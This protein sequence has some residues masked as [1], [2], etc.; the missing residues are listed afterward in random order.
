[1]YKMIHYG[2]TVCSVYLDA[3]ETLPMVYILLCPLVASY[4]ISLTNNNTVLQFRTEHKIKL[5]YLKYIQTT[6]LSLIK[7]MNSLTLFLM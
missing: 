7:Q 6:F 5:E 2:D 3:W 4:F 1:M